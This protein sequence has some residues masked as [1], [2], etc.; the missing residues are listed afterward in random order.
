MPPNGGATIAKGTLS[1]VDNAIDPQTG[2]IT[3]KAIFPNQNRALWPGQFVNVSAVLSERPNSVVIPAQAVQSGQKGQ[4]VYV[5]TNDNGVEMR[6]VKV[7]QAIDQQAVID[8]GVA[9]G[10]TVVTDGQLR[11]TP[12]SKVEVKR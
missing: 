7:A 3:L 1:F 2:T 12:K 11:L 9:A 5:V 8:H 10:E 6:P 4:F